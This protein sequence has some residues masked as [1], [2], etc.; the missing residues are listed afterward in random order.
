MLQKRLQ[1]F[2]P[3]CTNNSDKRALRPSSPGCAGRP[4]PPAPDRHPKR[5]SPC[6]GARPRGAGALLAATLSALWAD[7]RLEPKWQQRASWSSWAV[8]RHS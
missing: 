2:S 5:C 8:W 4:S 1:R 6:R 7:R 3:Y